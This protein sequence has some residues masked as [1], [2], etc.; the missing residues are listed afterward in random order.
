MVLKEKR[1]KLENETKK[2]RAFKSVR[3]DDT[4]CKFTTYLAI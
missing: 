4:F 3:K 2:L 1:A